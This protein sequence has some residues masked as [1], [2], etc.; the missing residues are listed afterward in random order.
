MSNDSLQAVSRDFRLKRLKKRSLYPLR[1]LYTLMS[2]IPPMT[3]SSLSNLNFN[4]S[5]VNVVGGNQTTVTNVYP[6]TQVSHP[7]SFNDAPVGR[8]SAYFTGREDDLD[9]V[10]QILNRTQYGIPNCCIIH[11]MPGVGKSQLSLC[12][13]AKSFDGGLYTYIFWTSATS[14]DKL[15][16][17]FSKVLDL[18]G[19]PDRHVQ[20]QSIKLT[21]AR[22]WLEDCSAHWLFIIDNVDKVTLD[23]LSLHFPR[24]N[25]QGNVL[26][27]TRTVDVAN[28]LANMTRIPHSTLKLP[29]LSLHDS[30][31]LLLNDA[32][33]R[34]Q[35]I[36]PVQLNYAEQLVESVGRLPL[37]V[38]QAASFI[39][40][41]D[42]TLDNMLQLYKSESKIEVR[43]V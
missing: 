4:H 29:T 30:I 7:R 3:S 41:T 11:G 27:T 26:F 19:H 5:I 25:A 37:A 33:I 23:F 42:T 31:C 15:T 40:Q 38:V 28:A 20:D 35:I 17:G 1:Q 10:E 24:I 8:L 16:Q 14:V 43:A 13:A 18:V 34:S 6:E 12:Y 36:T 21:T 32:G 22:L 2:H 39:K 9:R